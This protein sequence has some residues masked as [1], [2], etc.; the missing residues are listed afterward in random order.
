MIHEGNPAWKK[1]KIWDGVTGTI[2][3][4]PS[5]P[6]EPGK[7]PEDEKLEM[8]GKICGNSYR[9]FEEDFS[10]NDDIFPLDIRRVLKVGPETKN[11]IPLTLE[12]ESLL[13]D[14]STKIDDGKFTRRF[15]KK[16]DPWYKTE[17]QR[18]LM[19][20][21]PRRYPPHQPTYESQLIPMDDTIWREEY[22]KDQHFLARYFV[23]NLH[24]GTLLVNGMEI[25][26]GEVAG[27]LPRFAYIET[28]GGQ[29]SFWFGVGGRKHGEGDES[30]YEWEQW[31]DLRR[32]PGW[33]YTGLTS[34]E[35]WSKKINNR[36]EREKSGNSANDDGE[37]ENWKK[38]ESIK[39][40]KPY[41]I[42]LRLN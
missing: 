4:M 33:K 30:K 24:G 3:N 6:L 5:K 38:S 34:G 2:F 28:P 42:Y 22:E 21:P 19:D 37:W 23:T 39:T 25:R 31:R 7:E 36:A 17:K 11:P 9:D 40:S 32:L 15:M 16:D 18:I 13:Y 26:K 29:V 12:H 20:H 41:I 14:R 35:V 27:P 10:S 1:K 8:V